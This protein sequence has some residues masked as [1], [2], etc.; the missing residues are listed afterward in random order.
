MR[1]LRKQWRNRITRL[2]LE[3]IAGQFPSSLSGGERQRL[4]VARSLLCGKRVLFLDEPTAA[5]DEENKKAVFA[6]LERLGKD[7]L[8]ICS[9]HDEEAMDYA[10]S[11]IRID[12]EKQ[13]IQFESCRSEM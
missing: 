5:L 4:A 9:T 13:W 10:D 2:G 8:I 12:K 11:I 7:M 1:C 3:K 6:L